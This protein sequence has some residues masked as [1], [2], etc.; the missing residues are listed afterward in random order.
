MAN[1]NMLGV[2]ADCSRNAVMTVKTAEK[3]IDMLSK[4]GYNT[5]MLYTEDT[6]EVDGE[7]F[8]GYL[9]GRYSKEELLSLD[10]YASEKGIE[11]IPC[12]QTLAHLG[13]IFHW[14]EYAA[15]NDVNDIL[16]ADSEDTMKLIEKM[17]STLRSC[18]STSKIHIGM[19]EAHMLGLGKYLDKHGFCNRSEILLRHLCGVCELCKKYGFSP[20]MWSDMFF[21]LANKGEYG[22][23]ITEEQGENI[24]K[25]IPEDL[26]L[27]YWDYY[28]CDEKRY[29]EMI[30]GH[31]KLSD[32]VVFAGGVWTW[33]GFVPDNKYAV[34]VTTPAVKVCNESGVRD[35][36]LTAWGDDGGECS[37]FSA[38][39]TLFYAA[40]LYR[41]NSDIKNIK[42]RFHDIFAEDYDL[43]LSQ[44]DLNIDLLNGECHHSSKAILYSD[45]LMGMYDAVIP[46]DADKQFAALSEKYACAAEKTSMYKLHFKA[47]S[48]L[49]T[50]LSE[51][52]LLGIKLRK[53]YKENNREELE[54]L[55]RYSL[56]K[57]S[58]A[59][60]N[61]T[62][63]Y[64]KLWMSEKKP[65]GFDIEEIRLGGTAARIDGAVVR[66]KE[67]L[68]GKSE[69][70]PELEENILPV[71][72]FFNWSKT[73]SANVL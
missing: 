6:Y 10:K 1:K 71:K 36:L 21:R 57:A 72:P 44:E 41:G 26:T 67:Y 55:C 30:E 20:M 14:Q 13:T 9:R 56:P 2:M 63:I 42:E 64:R 3:L 70:I 11:L 40:E 39:P 43:V 68:D 35:I 59:V 53:A 28:S 65:H 51:K 8:F 15:V 66:L 38:L 18:V 4:M 62:E 17:L 34:S 23:E 54:E 22:G 58:E 24:R 46:E 50:A 69:S 29:R 5:I 7:P 45:I 49:A 47:L 27:V 16:L 52:S 12:I 48:A 19:D 61:F 60:R 37:I 32:K 25:L 33:S 31:K 73:V